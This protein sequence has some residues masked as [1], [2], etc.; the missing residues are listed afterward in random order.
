MRVGIIGAGNIGQAIGKRLTAAGHDVMISFAREFAKVAKAADCIGGHAGSP[1]QAADFGDAVLLATPWIVT[2]ELVSNIAPIL[3]GKTVWDATNP[4]KPDLSGLEFG[5]SISGGEKIAAALP[6][7]HVIKAIPPMAE[8]MALPGPLI[9][10]GQIP[11]V[12]V[13]GDNANAIATVRKLVGDVGGNPIAAGPLS[14]A[15]Y[16][17]PMGMLFVQLAYMQA[18]GTRIGSAFLHENAN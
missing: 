5:T 8:L 13:S 11:T 7:S 9:I 17:E 2:L 10:N 6:G 16:T 1:S 14:N 12:F 4:L 3:G 18:M 15:R